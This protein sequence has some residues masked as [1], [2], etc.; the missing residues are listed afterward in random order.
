[1]HLPLMPWDMDRLTRPEAEGML[2]YLRQYE[3]QLKKQAR[4]SK[5]GGR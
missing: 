4:A 1:M 2:G 5:P 3:A